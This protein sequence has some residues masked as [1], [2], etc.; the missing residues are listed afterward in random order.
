LQL[1]SGQAQKFE[2]AIP[3]GVLNVVLNNRDDHAK[4]FSFRM[5]SQMQWK[6]SSV[7]DL[8]F[9]IGPRGE[10]ETAV[11][12]ESRNP[13][14]SDLLKLAAACGSCATSAAEAIDRMCAGASRIATFFADFKIRKATR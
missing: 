4:N 12:G 14:R 13:G 10:H 7:Y 5:N 3:S 9:N 6:L 8:K 2:M 1:I 11:M